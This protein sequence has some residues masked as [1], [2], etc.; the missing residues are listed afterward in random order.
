MI[1]TY[2]FLYSHFHLGMGQIMLQKVGFVVHC[3]EFVHVN[4]LFGG[5]IVSGR[6]PMDRLLAML[7]CVAHNISAFRRRNWYKSLPSASLLI[8]SI[9]Y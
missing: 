5:R 2:L 4:G 7:Q 9:D 8:H 1:D 3:L 6:V